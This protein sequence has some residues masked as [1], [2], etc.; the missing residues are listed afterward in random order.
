MKAKFPIALLLAAFGLTGPALAGPAEDVQQAETYIR[1]GDVYSAMALLRKAA[2]QNNT[3]AQARLADLLHAA[4]FDAEALV[5]YRKAA[6]QGEPAAET[7]LGR[8]YADGT[9][10]PRDAALALE[11]YRK[12]EQKNYPPALDAL[13]RAYRTGSLGLAKDIEHAKELDTRARAL[14]APKEAK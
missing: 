8:M 4:E 9:G 12:A 3:A 6:A 10:V 7:G 14:A 5:L 2:D 11:W 13:A 1:T